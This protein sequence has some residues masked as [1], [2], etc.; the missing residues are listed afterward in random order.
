ME[1]EAIA[2]IFQAFGPVR[3]RRMFGGQGL[4]AGNWFI[5]IESGGEIWLKVDAETEPAFRVAGSAPFRY[6]KRSGAVQVMAFWRLPDDALDDPEEAAK[7][8][9]L[10]LGAAQRSAAA[11]KERHA[12]RIPGVRRGKR[13]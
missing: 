6:P 5:A 9:R 2:D 4:Y 1:A 11:R 7:W 3:T 8:A 13:A 12:R 10:A